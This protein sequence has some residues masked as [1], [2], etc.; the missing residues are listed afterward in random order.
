MTEDGDDPRLNHEVAR[1]LLSMKKD[2]PED[3]IKIC[4][5]FGLFG[6]LEELGDALERGL[7]ALEDEAKKKDN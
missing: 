1:V 7:P 3:F 5:A 4:E 2:A 6:D